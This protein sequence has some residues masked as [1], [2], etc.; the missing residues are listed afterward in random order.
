MVDA[1]VCGPAGLALAV[2]GEQ[3][4]GG[5]GL[6]TWEQWDRRGPVSPA[7]GLMPGNPPVLVQ[8]LLRHR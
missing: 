5:A 8:R 7:P 6:R 4:A 1:L 3:C 2:P